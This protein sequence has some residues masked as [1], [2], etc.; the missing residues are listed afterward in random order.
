MDYLFAEKSLVL[1]NI[2]IFEVK[3]QV[4]GDSR[5]YLATHIQN[6][7]LGYFILVLTAYP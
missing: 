1:Q 2:F 5:T 4:E 6:F 7:I 3:S